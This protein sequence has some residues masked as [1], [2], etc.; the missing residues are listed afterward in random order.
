M[1]PGSEWL[2]QNATIRNPNKRLTQPVDVANVAYLLC[3]AEAHWINGA[4][5][6][7]DGGERIA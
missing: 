4:I 7:V 3:R 6:P 2:K 5:I 1:I